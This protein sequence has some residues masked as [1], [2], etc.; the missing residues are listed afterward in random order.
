MDEPGQGTLRDLVVPGSLERRLG[1]FGVGV[2]WAL[3]CLMNFFPPSGQ[4]LAPWLVG[5]L[6]ALASLHFFRRAF[7]GRPRLVV[8]SEGV[9]DRT[10]LIGG[11]LFIPWSDI[12]DVA[13][14]KGGGIGLVV[15]DLE[16][17][18][19]RAGVIRRMWMKLEAVLGVRT[20]PI[21][22][23]LLGV[24]K[25]ELKNR[26]D[27]HLLQFERGDLGLETAPRL[28]QSEESHSSDD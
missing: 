11:S 6:S 9:T 13:V 2:F 26:L 24:G 21:M 25:R 14:K 17:V 7:D 4:A 22:L 28:R 19:R 16:A 18:Q 10:A 27:A 12:L 23:T 20:V 5:P 3:F 15:R 1:E 8:N